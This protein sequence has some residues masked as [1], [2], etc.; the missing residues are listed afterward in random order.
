MTKDYSNAKAEEQMQKGEISPSELLKQIIPDANERKNYKIERGY[1]GSAVDAAKKKYK[2]VSIFQYELYHKENDKWKKIKWDKNK[3]F[4]SKGLNNYAIYGEN[5][6]VI[7]KPYSLA[8]AENMTVGTPG[9]SASS[10]NAS[11]ASASSDGSSSSEMDN[12]S[13]G[14]VWY[15]VKG[16]SGND[17]A[18]LKNISFAKLCLL[19]ECYESLGILL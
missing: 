7:V 8:K 1:S 2:N 19:K 9:N 14:A 12:V 3:F 10:N 17:D 11:T 13:M 16:Y 15:D 5:G 4:N 18:I 6:I